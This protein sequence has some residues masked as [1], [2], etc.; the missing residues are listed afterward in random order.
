[1]LPL[2]SVSDLSG[3]EKASRIPANEQ[4]GWGIATIKAPHWNSACLSQQVNLQKQSLAEVV[5]HMGQFGCFDPEIQK[6]LLTL[7]LGKGDPT[8]ELRVLFLQRTWRAG[9]LLLAD[10]CTQKERLATDFFLNISPIILLGHKFTAA[11]APKRTPRA[12]FTLTSGTVP[13]ARDS[14]NKT[15]PA[16]KGFKVYL[17]RQTFQQLIPTN[18]RQYHEWCRGDTD[19]KN[20]VLG[21]GRLHR[22]G[23]TSVTFY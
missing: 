3:L 22:G 18:A 10:E 13:N 2:F 6:P 4:G 17:G 21:R 20:L 12:Q 15:F 14:V 16:W 8:Q 19:K 7:S 11:I 1:M 23:D 5:F 9:L